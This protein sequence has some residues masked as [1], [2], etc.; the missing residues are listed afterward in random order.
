MATDRDRAGMA[1]RKRLK[2]KTSQVI[3]SQTHRDAAGD[4][5]TITNKKRHK[6]NNSSLSP[7]SPRF[8]KIK[9]AKPRQEVNSLKQ[10]RNMSR[11]SRDSSRSNLRKDA[12][13]SFFKSPYLHHH[14]HD[15]NTISGTTE[16]PKQRKFAKIRNI[17]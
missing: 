2:K 11:K 16:L 17:S 10:S 12:S 13:Q 6:K 5:H 9:V 4:Y 15:F 1:E 8:N 7:I 3:I 14:N